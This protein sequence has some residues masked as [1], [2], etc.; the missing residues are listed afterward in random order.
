M[1]LAADD[2]AVAEYLP[3]TRYLA[4]RLK[5]GFPDDRFPEVEYD[6]LEQEGR[7]FVWQSLSR[8]IRPSSDLIR[9]R[10]LNWVRFLHAEGRYSYEQVL[11]LDDYRDVADPR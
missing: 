11:P 6:D 4:T 2:A 1:T 3:L 7:I 9:G 10:M 8:G 5:A